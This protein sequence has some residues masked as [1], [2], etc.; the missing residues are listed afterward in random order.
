M[1]R[2][3]Q[4]NWRPDQELSGFRFRIYVQDSNFRRCFTEIRLHPLPLGIFEFCEDCVVRRL[5]LGHLGR[6]GLGSACRPDPCARRQD[7]SLRRQE[8]L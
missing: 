4:G 8:A 6:L 5:R 2:H 1:L 7:L 3:V